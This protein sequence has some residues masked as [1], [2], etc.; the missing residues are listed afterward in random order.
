MADGDVS[1]KSTWFINSASQGNKQLR[2]MQDYNV[3]DGSSKEATN[4]VGSS[5]PTGIM[6]KPG[7]FTITLNFLQTKGAKPDVD[8]DALKLSGEWHSYTRQPEG[9]R[10]EQY[11]KCQV[12]K[13]DR[14]G[15][16]DGKEAYSVEII[17]LEKKSL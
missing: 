16:K 5:T 3:A 17:A 12:S 6:S 11:N 14:D 10:R 2:R 8:W 1:S 7:A 4:E 13:V 9:G 15:D